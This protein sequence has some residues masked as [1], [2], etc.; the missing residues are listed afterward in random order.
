MISNKLSLIFSTCVLALM[1]F[2]L[3]PFLTAKE[4]FQ[5]IQNPDY[6][7]SEGFT[8]VRNLPIEEGGGKD[9]SSSIDLHTTSSDFSNVCG[10]KTVKIII[11][12]AVM[13]RLSQHGGTFRLPQLIIVPF[14]KNITNLLD[15]SVTGVYG[16][17]PWQQTANFSYEKADPTLSEISELPEEDSFFSKVKLLFAFQ[18]FLTVPCRGETILRYSC[19]LKKT[20]IDYSEGY[21]AKK[22]KTVTLIIEVPVSVS[23]L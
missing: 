10:I 7:I 5:K 22:S 8:I 9:I 23:A 21:Q 15:I 3:T 16:Q 14:S 11:A 4:T 19:H 6:S 17:A 18:D 1:F 20:Y 2:L 12:D 13:N